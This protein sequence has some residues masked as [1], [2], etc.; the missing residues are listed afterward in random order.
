MSLDKLRQEVL[1]NETGEE[2]VEVNQRHLIDKILARY[3]AEFVVFRE[4]LQNSDDAKATNVEIIFM[5]EKYTPNSDNNICLSEKCVRII[6]KNNGFV[7]RS[8]DWNRLKKI[9]EGNPDEQKIGAFG[10]GFYSLF[11]VCD[12]PFVSSGTQGMAFYWRGDQLFAKRSNIKQD[13]TTWTTFLMDTREK[14]KLPEIE[15]FGRFLVAST[16]SRTF[17]N[18]FQSMMKNKT[19]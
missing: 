1:S 2:R 16:H 5:T 14:E 10:V 12:A 7:F 11:S 13:D 15:S 18:K 17:Q 4:L 9:A 3:S 19:L 8:E 6:F